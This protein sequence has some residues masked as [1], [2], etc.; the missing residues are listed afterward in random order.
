M[1][2]SFQI[3]VICPSVCRVAQTVQR[4]ATGWQLRGSN[5]GGGEIFRTCP[6]RTW[7]PPSLL[8]NGYR[9]FPGGKERS[10]RDADP[11][12]LSGAVVMKGQS[13]YSTPPVGRKAFTEPQCLYKGGR[14]R[15]YRDISSTVHHEWPVCIWSHERVELYLHSPYG[16]SDL[17]RASVPVQGC[18]LPYLSA[19][20]LA[21]FTFL[22][23]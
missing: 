21:R 20:R 8:Y 18:S 11:S 19:C 1:S 10:G 15:I 23:L 4:L 13:Y 9:V 12:L 2:K 6:D 14:Q 17:Y 22:P 16:P 5:P 7:G 3:P